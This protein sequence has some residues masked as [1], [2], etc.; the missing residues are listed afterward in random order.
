MREDAFDAVIVDMRMPDVS[1]EQLFRELEARDPS[2][3]ERVIFTTGQLVDDSV[4]TFLASTGRPC[5]PKPFEFSSFDQVLPA[6]RDS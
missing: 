6:R 2:Y 1:G 4:R 3:A 5:V